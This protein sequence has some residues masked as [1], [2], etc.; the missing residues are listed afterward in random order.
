MAVVPNRFSKHAFDV[1]VVADVIQFTT[2]VS[3]L[4][5]RLHFIFD[6]VNTLFTRQ[7]RLVQIVLIK[8]CADNKQ[9]CS[10]K[11]KS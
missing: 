10:R 1:I 4:I 5:S 3:I 2:F 8:R 11:N 6:M 7:G 9:N